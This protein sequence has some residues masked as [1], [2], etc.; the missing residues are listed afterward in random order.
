MPPASGTSVCAAPADAL[1]AAKCAPCIFD[2]LPSVDGPGRG[3]EPAD[4][5][6][7]VR[8]P[9]ARRRSR[10]TGTL[11]PEPGAGTM[12]VPVSDPSPLT[13]GSSTFSSGGGGWT[14]GGGGSGSVG[15]G[16]I[17][18]VDLPSSTRSSM[19]VTPAVIDPA[20]GGALSPEVTNTNIAPLALMR[21]ARLGPASS[22]PFGP[23]LRRLVVPFRRSRRK[24]S[25]SPFWSVATRFVAVEAKTTKRPSWVIEA[26]VLSPPTASC[27]LDETLTRSV[28][29]KPG[30]SMTPSPSVSRS[31]TK[32]SRRAVAVGGRRGWPPASRRQ[33]SG[34]RG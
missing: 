31:W 28:A 24:T 15:D 18:V 34:R 8:R 30:S 14:D 2:D 29:T 22:L 5:R 32:T 12:V 20:G 25:L 3:S 16:M 19:D 1:P 9:R 26:C 27:S 4:E 13:F 23:T 7:L 10:S 6:R 11:P 33:R 17:P 21:G